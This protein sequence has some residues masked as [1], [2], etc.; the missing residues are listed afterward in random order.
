MLPLRRPYLL[1]ATYSQEAK[2][3]LL[4]VYVY[5]LHDGGIAPMMSPSLQEMERA[6]LLAAYIVVRHGDKYAPLMERLEEEV[7]AA[8][9]QATK[10]ERAQMILKSMTKEVRHALP[11]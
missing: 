11:A 4:R 10:R 2:K 6:L 8:R 3:N 9:R 5:P 7:E 1:P